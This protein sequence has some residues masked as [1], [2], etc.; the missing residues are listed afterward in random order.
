MH[1]RPV[2]PLIQKI[3]KMEKDLSHLKKAAENSGVDIAEGM[4]EGDMNTNG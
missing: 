3:E 1:V 4:L 2:S